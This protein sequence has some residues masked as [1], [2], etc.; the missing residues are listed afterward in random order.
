MSLPPSF[1]EHLSDRLELAV[2]D[3]NEEIKMKLFDTRRMSKQELTKALD[4]GDKEAGT[5]ERQT[6]WDGQILK[7]DW[8][9]R[10]PIAQETQPMSIT[11][12][13]SGAF[14]AKLAE[15]RQ[16]MADSQNQAL[17]KIDGAVTDGAAKVDAA[18]EGVKA[19]VNKE[20]EDALQEFATVTNGGPV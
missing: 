7:V 10:E 12:L 6:S 2:Y 17:A 9:P 19:K 14:Q 8:V 15:M 4:D 18:V 3:T 16:K 1:F 5:T 11:G 13:Q 20:V